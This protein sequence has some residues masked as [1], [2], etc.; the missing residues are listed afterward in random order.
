MEVFSHYR[1][2]IPMPFQPDRMRKMRIK[3]K[4][5]LRELGTQIGL[6]WQAVQRYEQGRSEPKIN[7]AQAIAQALGVSTSYL[8]GETNEPDIIL[9][10]K[11]L[12]P[13]ER[14]FLWGIRDGNIQLS[15]YAMHEE[16]TKQREI[17]RLAAGRKP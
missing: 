8:V 10:M 17:K 15:N 2:G 7:R 11:D 9:A 5:T 6:H 1:K 12:E 16:A 14:E 3:R 13:G 4:L